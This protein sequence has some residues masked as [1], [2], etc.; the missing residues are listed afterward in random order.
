MFKGIKTSNT[1]NNPEHATKWSHYARN[2]KI[3]PH[4][5]LHKIKID[6]ITCNVQMTCVKLC[7]GSI[8]KQ[9]VT[10]F[11]A[12]PDS[13]KLERKSYARKGLKLSAP[14]ASRA[15]ASQSFDDI[16]DIEETVETDTL[17][18]FTWLV[19]TS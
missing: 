15:H 9:W 13:S 14:V 5:V 10:T 3:Y 6:F 4:R 19:E 1:R 18:G 8:V 11:T 2:T 7:D 17:L 12:Q 16:S